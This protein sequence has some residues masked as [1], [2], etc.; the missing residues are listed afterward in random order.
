LKTK[1]YFIRP[2]RRK[3]SVGPGPNYGCTVHRTQPTHYLRVEGSGNNLAQARRY[4]E[5]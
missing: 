4:F 1:K 2:N 5:M 3:G